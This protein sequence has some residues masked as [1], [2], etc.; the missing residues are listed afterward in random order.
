M[1]NLLGDL[2]VDG[3]EPDWSRARA[4][5]GASLHLYGKGRPAPGRK[6]GHLTVLRPD[7]NEAAAVAES[8]HAALAS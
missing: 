3:R 1:A 6:M 5:A 4:T 7:V 2:W 8:L